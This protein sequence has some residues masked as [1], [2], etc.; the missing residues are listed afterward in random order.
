MRI[1]GPSAGDQWRGLRA[2]TKE[3]LLHM[4]FQ[5]LKIVDGGKLLGNKLVKSGS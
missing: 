2:A 5:N 1:L 3:F 4:A